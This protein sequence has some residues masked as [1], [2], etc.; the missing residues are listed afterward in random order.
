MLSTL[1]ASIWTACWQWIKECSV[2]YICLFLCFEAVDG[3]DR[4]VS[5]FEQNAALQGPPCLQITSLF[6]IVLPS[7]CSG[8]T[9]RAKS[10]SEHIHLQTCV[11][12]E[13]RC[14]N[15]LSTNRVER[16][17]RGCKPKYEYIY[18]T[19]SLRC[20]ELR[21]TAVCQFTTPKLSLLSSV[22]LHLV[23]A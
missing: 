21:G 7:T 15:F 4:S 18:S 13:W 3:K 8:Y 10:P 23:C 5:Y 19:F 6:H 1:K 11:W 17:T 22:N 9:S 2:C 12:Y 20:R 14:S 16:L